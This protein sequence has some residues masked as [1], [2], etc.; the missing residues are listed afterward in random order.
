MTMAR[1]LAVLLA[2]LACHTPPNESTRVDEP[3]IPPRRAVVFPEGWR[4][5]AGA[6]AAFG[7][8]SMIAS[9]DRL[10][11]DAGSEILS[12]GGNAVDAAVAVGFALAV[13]YPAAGNVGGGGFMVIRMA[14]GRTAAIDYREVAPLSA[15]RDMYLDANGNPTDASIVGYRASGV[16]GSVAGM[17]E[18]LAKYGTMPLSRV[19]APAIRL[20]RD[21][22]VVDSFLHGSLSGNRAHIER[23]DAKDVFFPGGAPLAVGSRVRQP[24]LAR[25]LELI[26]A[27][28]ARVFYDGEIADSLVAAMQRGGGNI[29][30]EDLR[31]YRPA[32]RTP[33]RSTYRGYTMF[34]MP[35]ASSGGIVVTESLNILESWDSLPSWG[36]AAYAHVLGSTYQRAFIDRNSKLGDP[37]FVT[38]PQDELTSKAYARRLAAT[39]RPDRATPTP[40]NAAQITGGQN[41]THFSVVDEK[42]NAVA[43]T[44]TIN[45]PGSGYG[46]AVYLKNLGFF[47]NDEM[48]D[49]AAAPGK[50]N[51]FGLVQGEQNAI[52]PG[53]RML[54]AMSPTI[55]LD[56]K[57]ELLLVVGAAGGPRIITA[58]SQIILDVID[59]RM[60]LADAM[61]APRLHHQAL[62]DTL[63]V[64]A[65]GLTRSAEDSLLA[66][67][68]HIRYVPALATANAVMRVRGG[69][70]GVSE[71]RAGTNG[72]SGR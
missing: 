5:K 10:A 47:M 34:T 57:G 4:F 3:A 70:E 62:P 13:T 8:H 26:A 21:G 66:M 50:P 24:A 38:V 12:A 11:S 64:E 32:W 67:G 9:I 51:L 39:I 68:H 69:W 18:A 14:D 54:S 29:S 49:F 36:S 56:P 71:P 2:L 45:G 27:G 41:T 31:R 33:I 22:F 30:K 7:Q 59:H 20:A 28:G 58:T 72:T 40:P 52:A 35:P 65:N 15:S 37:A 42:G 16:P 63:L 19:M 46:S 55:V 25:T 60:T 23:F 43:A 1:S 6:R 17:A 61:Q 53:K 44:T 48:D